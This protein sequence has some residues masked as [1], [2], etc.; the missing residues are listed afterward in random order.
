M[1]GFYLGKGVPTVPWENTHVAKFNDLFEPSFAS[2]LDGQ[3]RLAHSQGSYV[4]PLQGSI[5]SSP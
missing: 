4:V 1:L 5:P 3:C 2:K